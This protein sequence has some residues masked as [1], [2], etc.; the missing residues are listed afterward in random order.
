MIIKRDFNVNK[1]TNIRVEFISLVKRGANKKTIIWKTDEGDKPD[2]REVNITKVDDDHRLVYGIVYSPDEIDT[3]EDFSTADEIEKAAHLFM[4]N[5]FS[6]NVDKDH[7]FVPAGAFV[8]ESWIVK[9]GDPIFPKEKPGAWAVGIK[10]EDDAIWKEVKD[11]EINGLSMGGFA[12]KEAVQKAADYNAA[13]TIDGMWRHFNALE[14]AI[15][16]IME[17][18]SI[19]DK[20]QAISESFDQFKAGFIDQIAVKKSSLF[21]KIL[22]KFR[23]NGDSEMKQED[24]Q[25][26]VDEAMAKQAKPMS[27]EEMG[28][29]VKTV[30]EDVMKPVNERLEKLEKQTPGTKQDGD[31]PST[32][33]SHEEL[34]A[35][36]L[37][38][39]KE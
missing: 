22:N 13:I 29:V 1:L 23:K 14:R 7:S 39:M 8:A 2:L 9:A 37:K 30:V 24:V 6:G 3:D 17:D 31:D 38:A 36:I 10:V 15:A 21:D 12:D 34:A 26:I 33:K 5:A 16:S 32:G 27:V 35:G 25:K 19:D 4:K 11:G 20:T 18:E 28:A